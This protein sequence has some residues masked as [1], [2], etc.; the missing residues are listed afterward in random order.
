MSGEERQHIQ[1]GRRLRGLLR[2]WTVF[3]RSSWDSGWGSPIGWAGRRMPLLPSRPRKIGVREVFHA[4]RSLARNTG[5]RTAGTR[6]AT[7]PAAGRVPCPGA[8]LYCPSAQIFS[9]IDRGPWALGTSQ[10]PFDSLFPAAAARRVPPPPPVGPNRWRPRLS[11]MTHTGP[12]SRQGP[13]HPP[14]RN[15]RRLVGA[16]AGDHGAPGHVHLFKDGLR[17][18]LGELGLLADRLLGGI[19]ALADQL[20]L[21]R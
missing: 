14:A 21:D 5:P 18:L 13:S 10:D 15:S 16:V 9:G 11:S 2:R 17:D 12:R 4:A 6:L 8:G 19:A 20:A 3:D 1:A 7:W